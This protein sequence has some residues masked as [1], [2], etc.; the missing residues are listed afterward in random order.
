MDKDAMDSKS[1]VIY[2]LLIIVVFLFGRSPLEFDTC[3]AVYTGRLHSRT[4]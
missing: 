3:P 1:L 4:I 2:I